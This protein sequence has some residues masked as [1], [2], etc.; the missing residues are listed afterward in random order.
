MQTEQ[1]AQN[2]F[3]IQRRIIE[4]KLNIV[5]IVITRLTF[6]LPFQI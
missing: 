4:F 2:R 1:T 6:L 3:R 5:V